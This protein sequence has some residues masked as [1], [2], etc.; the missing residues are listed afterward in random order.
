MTLPIVCLVTDRHRTAAG[1]PTI[2][3]QHRALI[4]LIA[5]A[6]RAGVDLVHIRERDLSGHDLH[7]LVAETVAVT[8]GS[9]TRVVVNDRADVALA[10]GA[11]G[12]HLPA[13]G[14][15]VERVRA[16]GKAGWLV[17]RSAHSGAELA[18]AAGADYIVF[19]TVFASDSKPGVPEQ[20][21]SALGEA[22]R[23]VRQPVLAIG[24]V[25]VE[26]ARACAMA[27]AAGVAAISLFLPPSLGGL[28]PQEA[29]RLLREQ[30]ADALTSGEASR[31]VESPV[32]PIHE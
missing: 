7:N 17:G 21:T 22:V 15:S 14:L 16:L 19:G 5:D 28:G 4:A 3:G 20:G 29:V 25:T 23:A 6:A 10:A 12:V 13:L 32:A 2:H 31:T 26:R 1:D 9:S 24:G 8:R 27:G 18:A 11:D 30:F